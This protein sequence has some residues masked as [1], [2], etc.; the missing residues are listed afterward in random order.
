MYLTRLLSYVWSKATRWTSASIVKSCPLK[1]IFAECKKPSKWIPRFDRYGTSPRDSMHGSTLK[2]FPR[3]MHVP[4]LCISVFSDLHALCLTFYSVRCSF[5]HPTVIT[6]SSRY[7]NIKYSYAMVLL[8]FNSG[9]FI[10]RALIVIGGPVL[11]LLLAPDARVR[12][13]GTT[14]NTSQYD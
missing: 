12:A 9:L 11:S 5:V 14:Y 10:H 4:S 8:T 6:Q 13:A 2:W 1:T 3:N 7:I